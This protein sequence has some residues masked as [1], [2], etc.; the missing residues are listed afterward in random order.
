MTWVAWRQQRAELVLGAA[1]LAVL[2]ALFIPTGLHMSGAYETDGAAACVGTPS[3]GCAQLLDAFDARFSTIIGV[4]G[5]FAFLPV[6]IAVIFAAPFVLELER[7]TYRLAWTQSI[8][9]R[10]WLAAKLTIALGGAGLAAAG[11]ALLLTW[12]RRPLDNFHGRIE[13]GAFQLEGIA[14]I[15][16]AMFAAALIIA[17]GTIMRRTIAAIG[18]GIVAFLAVRVAIETLVRPHF[19]STL[20]AREGMNLDTAWVVDGRMYH[21]SSRFW[22]FQGIETSLYLVL[23]LG[24]LGLVAWLIERRVS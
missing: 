16:Y 6:V 20:Q 8:T 5:W 15:A 7:G 1:V 9:R 11:T 14:P 19:A 13:P 23:T 17:L 18:L 3:G 10:R 21:P 24:L 12:W 2:A 4:T 22:A